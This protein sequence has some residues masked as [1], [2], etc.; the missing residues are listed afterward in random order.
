[1]PKLSI[2]ARSLDAIMVVLLAI[3]V[4]LPTLVIDQLASVLGL[5]SI[6]HR[7]SRILSILQKTPG[8]VL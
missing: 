1:M 7:T 5:S 6:Q 4:F 2:L 3:T 8:S